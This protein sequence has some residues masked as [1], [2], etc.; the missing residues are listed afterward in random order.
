[1]RPGF[2]FLSCVLFSISIPA[3]AA[4]GQSQPGASNSG[5]D[6]AKPKR[7]VPRD[8]GYFGIHFDLHPNKGDT[9]LGAD[10]TEENIRRLLER[11]RPDFV[12]YDC[13]G[14]PGYTGY[15]TKVGWSA[16]GIVKDSLA[17]WRKTT[18]EMGVALGIHYSGVWDSVAVEKHPE[19]A[20]LD[21]DGQPDGR[22]T[23]T[24]GP[25]VDKLLIPQLRE[26]VSNYDLDFLWVDGECWAAQ[27]DYCP[28]ALEAW[29]R[30][31][32]YDEAPRKRSDPHWLEWKTFHRRRFETYL[33]HWV[34]ALHASHPEL[35]IASNWMYTTF[36]PKPVACRVD[37]LSG[38]YS[39]SN[40]VDRART[41]ARYL[42][43]VGMP[44]DLLA[45]GFDRPSTFKPAEHLKQ[46]AAESILHG[47][48]F[49]IYY[50]PTRSGHVSDLIINT[51]GAVA[52]F[53]RARQAVSFR[54]TSVPQVALLLSAQTQFDRSDRVFAPW[55]AEMQDVDGALHALLELHYSVDILAEW[56]LQ[57]RLHEFP[58]VVIPD[59]SRLTAEFRR[60]LL[61]YVRQGGSL[62]LMGQQCARLFEPE[63]GV[64][65]EGQVVETHADLVSSAGV[66]GVQGLWQDVTPT[67]ATP[68]AYRYRGPGRTAY[69]DLRDEG[70]SPQYRAL[71]EKKVAATVVQY[72]KGRIATV[73]GPVALAFYKSHHP[74]LRQFIGEIVGRLFPMPAVDVDGPPCL[75]IAL[76]R[77][78]DG[79]LSLHMMDLA[80][81]P[82]GDRHGFID[83][84]PPLGPVR[85]KLQVPKKP[86][87]VQWIPEGRPIEWAWSNGTLT[88]TVPKVD[89][90]GVLV[91]GE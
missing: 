33:A 47:G 72:G 18:R 56:N 73:Y 75:E 15:P 82:H 8:E 35:K 83:Y 25:Y 3:L 48:G 43:N 40:S 16:P 58:L 80:N 57:P 23:S 32:G 36:A 13:K 60:A 26:A 64:R 59:A 52:D 81:A 78:R 68:I 34:D 69:T 87:S 27:L 62:F 70:I 24:F 9:V 10:V 1:M 71:M 77:T 29:K 17:I 6:P 79:R 88:A 7:R 84:I 46:E 50:N 67:T 42:C 41:E 45:W 30:Q 85:V 89:I 76:R 63:L 28:A 2:R 53:C 90:H 54:S 21:A 65:F 5:R 44:W 11:V 55:A 31:T 12:Q 61:D 4:F 22:N 86:S 37:Y 91:V 19:W 20:R 66:V 14:H 74:Y 38:D 51:A 39:P 49:S